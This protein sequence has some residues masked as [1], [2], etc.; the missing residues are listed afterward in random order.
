M[1]Q[2]NPSNPTESLTLT[3]LSLHHKLTLTPIQNHP[4][5]RVDKYQSIFIFPLVINQF[6]EARVGDEFTMI[7]NDALIKCLLPTF[8]ADTLLVDGGF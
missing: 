7:G 8:L 5:E 4:D 1:K 6:Y 3:S 2:L